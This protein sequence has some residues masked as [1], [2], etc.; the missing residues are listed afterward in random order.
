MTAVL[1][2]TRLLESLR[3]T[4]RSHQESRPSSM[5]ERNAAKPQRS[6]LVQVLRALSVFAA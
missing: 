6:F 1:N 4:N 2:P 3:S 5:P